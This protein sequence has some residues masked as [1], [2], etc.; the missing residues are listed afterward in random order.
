MIVPT[1]VP[2]PVTEAGLRLRPETPAAVTVSVAVLVTP[3]PA[4]EIVDVAL[5][6][7]V[8]PA[9]TVKVA[10][11]EPAGTVTEAGTVAAVVLLDV[12]VTVSPVPPALPERVTVP[13]EVAP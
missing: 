2:L 12:S 10:V 6:E 7:P 8:A 4:A 9:V 5:A 13:V 1:D 11:E 3:L